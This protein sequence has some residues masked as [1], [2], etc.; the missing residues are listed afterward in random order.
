MK[1]LLKQTPEHPV[2][3]VSSHDVV[4]ESPL[5]GQHTAYVYFPKIKCGGTPDYYNEN[6]SI[7]PIEASVET[8]LSVIDNTIKTM[9]TLLND[10][11]NNRK[12]LLN[13][14]FEESD[15]RVYIN[16]DGS[17]KVET[18]PA[19]VRYKCRRCEAEYLKRYSAEEDEREAGNQGWDTKGHLC[20]GCFG[21]TDKNWER[22]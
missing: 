17:F 13:K 9:E 12:T 7:R 20:P 8:D 11:K 6:E 15:S 18:L 1:W 2:R 22:E 19:N 4:N 16:Q 5:K 3:V 14:V 21:P 10:L